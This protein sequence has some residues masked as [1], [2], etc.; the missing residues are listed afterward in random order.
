M[1][2]D[3]T[4][5]QSV[6][7]ELSLGKRDTKEK[8]N[9]P[10]RHGGPNGR[11]AGRSGPGTGAVKRTRTG[12]LV[13]Q[14]PKFMDRARQNRS[15]WNKKLNCYMWTTEW[16]IVPSIGKEDNS[17]RILKQAETSTIQECL[18]EVAPGISSDA[19]V[20]L[21]WQNSNN[22]LVK[23]ELQGTLG[24]QLKDKEIIEFPSFVVASLAE[25]LPDMYKKEESETSSDSDSDSS[26]ESSD[27]ESDSDADSD[28]DTETNTATTTENI[29][30]GYI[31]TVPDYNIND[32]SDD[33]SESPPEETS[34]KRPCIDRE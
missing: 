10:N 20:Y 17:T 26:S 25:E 2:R 15:G 13:T 29:D 11:F 4:F 30:Q 7:R 12:I 16:H 32:I 33:D 18:E 34:S 1:N 19:L 23:L 31:N 27:S 8:L 22:R 5:L 3:Y 6:K 14:L 24:A 28:D 21:K 9:L